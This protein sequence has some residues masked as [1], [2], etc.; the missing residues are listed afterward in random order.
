MGSTPLCMMEK[1]IPFPNHVKDVNQMIHS[2]II[3]AFCIISIA[4]AIVYFRGESQTSAAER[5][6]LVFF[7]S[8]H[9]FLFTLG[10]A[11]LYTTVPL[12]LFVV[13]IFLMFTSR[14]CNGLVLL[15]K[16]NWQ[17]YLVTG[18]IMVVVLILWLNNI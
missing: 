13:S 2:S 11:H 10:I 16:N 17:H 18:L 7:V 3:I 8:S 4:V 14:V 9:T 12:W 15:G 5:L 6:T 1:E